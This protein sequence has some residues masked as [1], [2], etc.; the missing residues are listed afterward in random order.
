MNEGS[1]SEGWARTPRGRRELAAVGLFMA[2][3]LVVPLL[4]TEMCPFSR[5]PMFADAPRVY[6]TFE[7]FDPA[8]NE[9]PGLEFGLQRN[10]WG[11]PL[12]V[13]VGYRPPVSVDA[14]GEVASR[15]QVEEMVVARLRQRPDLPW[16]EVVQKEIGAVDERRVGVRQESRWRISP[17]PGDGS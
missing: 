6:Q 4:T 1:R 8:G 16:V 12:G 13:G 5:A 11:N 9:L 3:S 17:G 15:E 10:Y 7:I 14:F 2:V